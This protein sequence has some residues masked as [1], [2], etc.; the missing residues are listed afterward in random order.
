MKKLFLSALI[1][2]VTQLT[3]C[4]SDSDSNTDS[5]SIVGK[6]EYFKEGIKVGDNE[7]LMP[8]DH[9]NE[10]C[11]KDFLEF[12]SNNVLL[13]NE[14]DSNCDL[15]SYNDGTYTRTGNTISLDNGSGGVV[16]A[17]IKELT[18]STLKY[19]IPSTDGGTAVTRVLLL[20]KK[21]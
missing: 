17:T 13:H 20:Q 5:I 7:N 8:Y 21:P 6:W 14:Y 19:Y 4:S 2:C 12:K 9:F 1:V 16:N 18:N 11:G 10:S 15:N 3:S